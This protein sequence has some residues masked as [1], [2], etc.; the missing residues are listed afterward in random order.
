[1]ST[2]TVSVSAHLNPEKTQA[3]IHF[4]GRSHPIVCGCLGAE[5]NEQ[6]VI[7]TIYLDS[8]VHRHSSSVS[9]QGWQPEG[10]VSTILR[11]LTAA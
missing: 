6:G 1:M 4:S 5:T 9:Y 3:T 8:L 10:A 2:I 11:R 7:E